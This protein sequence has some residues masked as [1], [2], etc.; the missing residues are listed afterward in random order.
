MFFSFCRKNG[1]ID[2]SSEIS[3][4]E[5]P[6]RNAWYTTKR[7]WSVG[8]MRS[9]LIRSGVHSS[10]AV[11]VPVP[12]SPKLISMSSE[13]TA[14]RSASSIVRPIAITSPVLFIAVVSV[15]SAVTNLSKGHLGIFATT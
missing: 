9:S 3:S 10:A 5:N 15:L 4:L 11:P 12:A 13:R 7:R 1:S 2:V 6:V 14:L 8:V